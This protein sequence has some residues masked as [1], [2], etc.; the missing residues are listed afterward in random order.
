[1]MQHKE[2]EFKYF[3][4]D[5][6]LTAFVNF[7]SAFKGNPPKYLEASG[8]DYFFDKADDQDGF[9]RIRIGHDLRQLTY[10]HKTKETN[11]YVRDEHNLNF[12]ADMTKEYI[13]GYVKSLGYEYNTKLFKNCF[14]YLY[15]T[16]TLVYYICY[17]EDM[18]ELGRF[19]EIEMKEE[20]E[21][22]TEQA[23]WGELVVL[24]KLC[25]PLGISPQ[26]RVKRSLFEMFK[27]DKQ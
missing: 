12:A 23:A 2:V 18:H 11:N 3:A 16:F 1:M 8:Y 9:Y 13:E 4:K 19:V 10:K 25:R 26:A 24:E 6:P 5:I 20:H 21:W 17:D 22:G 14:I 15:D 7:C 27:K